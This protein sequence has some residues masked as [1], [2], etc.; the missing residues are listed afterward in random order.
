MTIPKRNMPNAWSAHIIAYMTERLDRRAPAQAISEE[1]MSGHRTCSLNCRLKGRRFPW[2]AHT[3]SHTLHLRGL[4]PQQ[5][6]RTTNGPL[7]VSCDSNSLRSAS[8]EGKKKKQP[9]NMLVKVTCPGDSRLALGT[10][11]DTKLFVL[12]ILVS[13]TRLAQTIGKT[14]LI[15]LNHRSDKSR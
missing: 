3:V 6:K 13:V 4:S 12:Y 14:L 10:N 2:R 8:D 11:T 15:N 5:K 7:C 9:E 1:R